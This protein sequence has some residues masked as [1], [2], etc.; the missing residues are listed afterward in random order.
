MGHD[1]RITWQI[2]IF[3]LV[4]LCR[5]DKGIQHRCFSKVLGFLDDFRLQSS[6]LLQKFGRNLFSKQ[7]L[8]VLQ[9]LQSPQH[10]QNKVKDHNKGYGFPT[11]IPLQLMLCGP[12]GVQDLRYRSNDSMV[13][14]TPGTP[15]HVVFTYRLALAN[16]SAVRTGRLT[17][18]S[19]HLPG[20]E[21]GQPYVL[22]LLE[23]CEGARTSDPRTS[24]PR[25]SDPSVVCF[26][27]AHVPMRPRGALEAGRPGTST[28]KYSVGKYFYYQNFLGGEWMRR[29]V[30]EEESGRGGGEWMGEEESGRG[31]EWMGEEESGWVRRRVGEEQSGWVRRRVDG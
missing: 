24:D 11:L 25:T 9:H 23:E 2:V 16:G 20:L 14:W 30:G 28:T 19:L 10:I 26:Q 22:D 17:R 5:S 21:T 7:E 15:Q 4:L 1:L 6:P 29:R 3:I 12:R 18:P 13:L 8:E 31:G 27:G